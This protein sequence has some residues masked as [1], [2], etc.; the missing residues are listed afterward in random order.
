MKNEIPK[1]G[2]RR[3]SL[4]VVLDLDAGGDGE[5]DE[6]EGHDDPEEILVADVA[7]DEAGHDAW[8][9]HATEVLACRADGED[10]CGALTAGEGDE[11]EGVG[12]ESES[13]A[14]LLDADAGAD[15]PEVVGG[16][17]AE[18]DIDDVGQGD[19]EDEG[20]EA[21]L[22]AP[23]GHSPSTND[24][25]Q[26]QADDAQ[27][28]VDE[29]EI[30][31]IH[32]ESSLIGTALEEEGND[33]GEESLGQTEEEDEAEGGDEVGLGDE[34]LEGLSELTH[35]LREVEAVMHRL[36][37]LRQDEGMIQSQQ[38]HQ[39]AKDEEDDHP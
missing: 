5:G 17:I 16:E 28:A 25:T 4:F 23:L 29:P 8:N 10:G 32:G 27:R 33:L 30:D 9:H 34:D 12:G 22:Q 36:L 14:Y 39:A 18:I 3:V 1:F 7:G 2:K 11:V 6:A 19:A 24:A 37:H 13:V 38:E 21:S 35:L 20:P 15:E 26:Q 31:I